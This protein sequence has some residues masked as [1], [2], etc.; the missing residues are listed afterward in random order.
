MDGIILSPEECEAILSEDIGDINDKPIYRQGHVFNIIGVPYVLTNINL[1]NHCTL[2]SL[3]DGNC[4]CEPREIELPNSLANIHKT[5]CPN[6]K[7][8]ALG[9]V[10]YFIDTDFLQFSMRSCTGI[11]DPSDDG[12]T[13][14]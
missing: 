13:C 2:V 8:Q 10:F 14:Q 7:I 3:V 6:Q 9:H 5:F 12:D 4:W 1:K 11:V